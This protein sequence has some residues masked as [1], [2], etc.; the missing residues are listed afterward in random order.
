MTTVEQRDDTRQIIAAY[1]REALPWCMQD[2]MKGTPLSKV[3]DTL[4]ASLFTKIEDSLPMPVWD[5]EATLDTYSNH[6]NDP[7]SARLATVDDWRR[8]GFALTWDDGVEDAMLTPAEVLMW[9]GDAVANVSA[10]GED[11]T[12]QVRVVRDPRHD[13]EGS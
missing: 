9:L 4:A 3:A 7:N 6:P 13:G 5:G 8:V 12:L 1:L 11:R 2:M 10:D